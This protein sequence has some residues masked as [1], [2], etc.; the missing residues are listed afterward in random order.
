MFYYNGLPGK[1]TVSCGIDD[2][3]AL[4][5]LDKQVLTDPFVE[6]GGKRWEWKGSLGTG[7][8]VFFWPDEPITRFGL[9]LQQPEKLSENAAPVVLAPGEHSARFGCRGGLA[10]PIRVRTTSQPSERHEIR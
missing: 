6:I 9:P 10:L 3:K 8:Y 2:V 7:Q 5:T 1:A 4:R